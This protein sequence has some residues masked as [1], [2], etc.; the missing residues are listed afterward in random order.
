MPLLFTLMVFWRAAIEIYNPDRSI[1][2]TAVIVV[3]ALNRS[4]MYS[5][6]HGHSNLPYFL[7][8]YTLIFKVTLPLFFPI[9]QNQKNSR[10]AEGEPVRVNRIKWDLKGNRCGK[11]E[12]QQVNKNKR[13]KQK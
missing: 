9:N 6:S 11:A 4:V 2:S 8:I 3:H 5:G 7:C 10:K 13:A 1:L 12:E